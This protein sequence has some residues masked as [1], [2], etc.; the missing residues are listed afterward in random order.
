MQIT[1]FPGGDPGRVD[2]EHGFR[3]LAGLEELPA[4]PAIVGNSYHCLR[5][6]ALHGFSSS[7]RSSS[8][9]DLTTWIKHIRCKKHTGGGTSLHRRMPSPFLISAGASGEGT[10]GK[11]REGAGKCL[12]RGMS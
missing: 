3:R 12:G 2:F 4:D 1:V 11:G 8:V 5:F 6:V 10:T 9:V 7:F